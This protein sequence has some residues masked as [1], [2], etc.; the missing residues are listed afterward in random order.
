[1]SV[2]DIVLHQEE[3]TALGREL[4]MRRALQDF[5]DRTVDRARQTAPRHT[6]AGADSIHVEMVLGPLGWEARVS[7]DVAHRYMRYQRSHAIQD[8]AQRIGR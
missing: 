3:I 4:W 8:A 1:M 5:G 6:G 2:E 7:W